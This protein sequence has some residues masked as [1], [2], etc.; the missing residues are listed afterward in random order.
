MIISRVW[1]MPSHETFSIDYI[2]Q[3]VERYQLRSAV[4]VDPFARDVPSTYSND[5]NP[6]TK[7]DWHMD[8]ADFLEML[9][10]QGVKADLILFD[11]PYSLR[12]VKEV[13]ASVG[14][15]KLPMDKTHG[16]RRERDAIAQL[17][18]PD[19]F[20]ISFGWNSQGQGRKR[21]FEIV[22][23]LLVAHG[24]DHNDTIVTVERVA[25]PH[26]P[27]EIEDNTEVVELAD[28]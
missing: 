22:E 21:G 3:L 2:R 18:N 25:Q 14:I 7:A 11:P 27:M 4:V 17:C 15:E 16:W 24:R 8:S 5:L 10:N 23:I 9:V 28:T 19:G 26:L 6:A 1:A 12:Q 13:Y 20:V